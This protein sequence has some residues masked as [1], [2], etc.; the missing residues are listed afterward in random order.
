MRNPVMT[1]SEAKPAIAAVNE[2][3]HRSP[4]RLPLRLL[5]PHP[6]HPGGQARAARAAGPKRAVLDRTLSALRAGA[7]GDAGRDGSRPSGLTRGCNGGDR[8]LS[9]TLGHDGVPHRESVTS[10]SPACHDRLSP[11][12]ILQNLQHTTTEV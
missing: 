3:A 6:R 11:S 5:Q 10:T 1:K 7:R 8:G 4:A 2:R 12:A 9:F